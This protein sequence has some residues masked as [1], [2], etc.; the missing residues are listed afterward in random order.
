[1]PRLAGAIV[2]GQHLG[3]AQM[4]FFDGREPRQPERLARDDDEQRQRRDAGAGQPDK[5]EALRCARTDP[6]SDA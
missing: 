3:G 4:Q 6:R 2:A 1:M 5:A